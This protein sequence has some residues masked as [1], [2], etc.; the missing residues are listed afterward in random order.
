MRQDSKLKPEKK[1]KICDTFVEPLE[2][3]ASV[4][5][6]QSSA[7]NHAYVHT[8]T[9]SH[10]G[11]AVGMGGVNYSQSRMPLYNHTDSN[12][13]S[14]L[15][16]GSS[17]CGMTTLLND[18]HFIHYFYDIHTFANLIGIFFSKKDSCVSINR[19]KFWQIS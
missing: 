3:W 18:F 13:S 7:G 19:T 14:R 10:I 9:H 11:A 4:S 2:N 15:N 5:E 12:L 6:S 8:H 16:C 17:I 1:K